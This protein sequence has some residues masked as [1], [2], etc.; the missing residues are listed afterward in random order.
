MGRLTTAQ[1]EPDGAAQLHGRGR[2][3]LPFGGLI[4]DSTGNLY[5]TTAEGGSSTTNCGVVY[6]LDA[7]GNETVLY[8]FTGGADGCLPSGG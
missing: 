3:G 2:W 1:E 4:R 6:K 7:A 5:G 8:S